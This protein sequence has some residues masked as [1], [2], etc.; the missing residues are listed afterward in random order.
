MFRCL[1]F[2]L[3]SATEVLAACRTLG[4]PGNA[5]LQQIKDG[6]KKKAAT[7]HPDVPGGS[8]VQMKSVNAAFE[9]LRKYPPRQLPKAPSENDSASEDP[10]SRAEVYSYDPYTKKVKLRIVYVVYVPTVKEHAR[11]Q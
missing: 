11:R 9:Y 5:T 3:Q 4:V 7:C 10:N 1:R 8:E 6:Y 2:H